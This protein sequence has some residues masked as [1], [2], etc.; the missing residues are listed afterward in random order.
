MRKLVVV[1]V[2][3]LAIFTFIREYKVMPVQGIGQ[4]QIETTPPN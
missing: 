2:A 4:A 1:I 3:V